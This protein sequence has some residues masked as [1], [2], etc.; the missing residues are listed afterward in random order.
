M[1]LADF[2]D[3]SKTCTVQVPRVFKLYRYIK[4]TITCTSTVMVPKYSVEPM[5]KLAQYATLQNGSWI[6][7]LVSLVVHYRLQRKISWSSHTTVR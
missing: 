5:Y 3:E 2:G 1:P 4:K 6:T 7:V